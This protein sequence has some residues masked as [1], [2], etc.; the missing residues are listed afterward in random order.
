MKKKDGWKRRWILLLPLAPFLLAL[1]VYLC[2]ALRSGATGEAMAKRLT[3]AVFSAFRVYSMLVFAPI[4]NG[5]PTLGSW[6]TCSWIILEI[7]RWG[8]VA[9]IAAAALTLMKNALKRI[10]VAW[11]AKRKD[12]YA[13]YGDAAAVSALKRE[14]GTQAICADMEEKM[15]RFITSSPL[16]TQR[17]STAFW[18]K[19]RNCWNGR[20]RRSIFIPT[21]GSIPGSLTGAS[22]SAIW[23]RTARG[24]SGTSIRSAKESGRL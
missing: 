8:A 20:R 12:V 10:G 6:D 17:T 13:V 4:G 14:L 16:A 5:Q 1:S 11:L 3:D 2:D 21:R 22:S 7:A 18:M 9:V 23:R 19:T 15:G 24:C